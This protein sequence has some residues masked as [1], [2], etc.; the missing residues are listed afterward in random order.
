MKEEHKQ[1]ILWKI[2]KNKNMKKIVVKKL[3]V[4]PITQKRVKEVEIYLGNDKF[5]KYRWNSVYKVYN[6]IL[7]YAQLTNK[8]VEHICWQL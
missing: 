3:L 7:N 4:N 6:S 2:L 1:M 8:Q 5:E